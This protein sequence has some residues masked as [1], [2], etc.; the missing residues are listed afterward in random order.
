MWLQE[1]TKRKSLMPMDSIIGFEYI[2]FSRVFN[3]LSSTKIAPSG[4]PNSIDIDLI[5]DARDSARFSDF[6]PAIISV[7]AYPSRNSFAA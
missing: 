1:V 2:R 4:I 7:S 6:P 5:V 3:D